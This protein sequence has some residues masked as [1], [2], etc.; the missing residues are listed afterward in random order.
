MPVSDK[1]DVIGCLVSRVIL[2]GR[3]PAAHG[4]PNLRLPR[5]LA[6]RDPRGG[7][8]FLV[9]TTG[10]DPRFPDDDGWFGTATQPDRRHPVT[11]DVTIRPRTARLPYSPPSTPRMPPR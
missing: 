3:I 1:V 6:D 11:A 5:C 7:G 9:A 4:V 8:S 2:V 10:W